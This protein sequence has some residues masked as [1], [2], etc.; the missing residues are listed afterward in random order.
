MRIFKIA[1]L[2]GLVLLTACSNHK[3]IPF[4]SRVEQLGEMTD[5][6]FTDL[7]GVKRNHL[8]AVQA[9][10]TNLSGDNQQLYYKFKWLDAK[11]FEI[12]GEEA[13]KPVLVYAYEKKL[14]NS[15][16]P[17]PQVSDFKVIVQSTNNT[18]LLP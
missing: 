14:I 8:L 5:L 11:G 6:Q 4:N 15:V 18:G 13:W 7:R 16:A 17:S 10:V 12:G 9:T 2:M 1:S 3:P